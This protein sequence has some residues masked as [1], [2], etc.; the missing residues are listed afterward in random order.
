VLKNTTAFS[1]DNINKD[2][3]EINYSTNTI[4][5]NINLIKFFTLFTTCI[6]ARLSCSKKM[7]IIIK[8]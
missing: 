8:K 2:A 6:I 4:G 3:K 1:V 5:R 7:I